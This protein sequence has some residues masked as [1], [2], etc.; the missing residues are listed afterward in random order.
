MRKC[1]NCGSKNLELED[2]VSGDFQIVCC[3]DCDAVFE[4]HQKGGRRSKFAEDEEEELEQD[5]WS[6]DSESD[7][8]Y[9]DDDD[10][11]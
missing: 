10:D 4:L 5:D 2:S 1:Q 9:N 11:R 6:D 3:L 7:L 8:D